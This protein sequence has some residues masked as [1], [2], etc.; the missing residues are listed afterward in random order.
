VVSVGY[1]VRSLSL[2][3]FEMPW[4]VAYLALL[5]L[6]ILALRNAFGVTI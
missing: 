4:W 3:G 2:F 1:P 6:V 5:F